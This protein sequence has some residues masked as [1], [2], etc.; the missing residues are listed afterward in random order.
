MRIRVKIDN[1]LYEVE[2]GDLSARPILATVDGETFEVYPE[3][4]TSRPVETST[5]V[6]QPMHETEL[7][8]VAS[9]VPAADCEPQSQS[10]HAAPGRSVVAPIPGVI[11]SIAVKPGDTV[12]HG[13]ELCVLEAM[14]MKNSIRATRAGKIATIHISSG[15]TVSHGQPLMDFED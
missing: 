13:H 12:Q 10:G 1:E 3:E 15:D 14:K 9:T 6:P 8:P 5:L 7:P 11:L 4:S 2:V